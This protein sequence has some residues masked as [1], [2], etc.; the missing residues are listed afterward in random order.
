VLPAWEGSTDVSG[1]RDAVADWLNSNGFEAA[2]GH[3][4]NCNSSANNLAIRVSPDIGVLY[5]IAR[6]GAGCGD[7]PNP[8]LGQ[9]T[10][11]RPL[12]GYMGQW[13]YVGQGIRPPGSGTTVPPGQTP[14]PIDQEDRQYLGQLRAAS[15]DLANWLNQYLNSGDQELDVPDRVVLSGLINNTQDSIDLVQETSPSWVL[16]RLGTMTNNLRTELTTI[17]NNGGNDQIE[18]V[19]RTNAAERAV[20]ILNSLVSSIEDILD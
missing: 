6:D 9:S 1:F 12:D 10:P 16:S 8:T 11:C 14:G 20:P 15:A 13:S 7:E 17:E 2:R 3:N 19:R 5:E 4:G 18:I